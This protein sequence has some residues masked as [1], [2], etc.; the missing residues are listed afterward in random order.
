[1]YTIAKR[2][3]ATLLDVLT[4]LNRLIKREF[5]ATVIF[6]IA[7]NKKGYSIT[8]NLGRAYCYREGIRLQIR[9]LHTKEQNGL[10]ERLGKNLIV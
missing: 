3:K 7:N 2:D 1:V 6:L 8:D 4:R 9:A 5:N 10:A